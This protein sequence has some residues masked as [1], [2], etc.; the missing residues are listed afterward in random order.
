MKKVLFA[1][2]LVAAFGL[3]SCSSDSDSTS[4]DN[5]VVAAQNAIKSKLAGIML[6]DETP[7]ADKV[8]TPVDFHWEAPFNVVEKLPE[9]KTPSAVY[10]NYYYYATGDPFT[11][12]MLYSNGLY[13]HICGIY[14]YDNAGNYYEEDMWD[15]RTLSTKD[16]YN[17]N[18][19]SNTEKK[20]SRLTDK[21]GAYEI[22]L[23][24]NTK[25]GFYQKSYYPSNNKYANIVY[26]TTETSCTRCGGDGKYGVIKCTTCNGTGKIST[27][28]KD[29]EFKFFSELSLNWNGKCQTV[30][31]NIDESDWT[32]VGLEDISRAGTNT[33]GFTSDEDFNDCVFAVNP[34]LHIVPLPVDSDTIVPPPTP[35]DP[36][37]IPTPDPIVYPNQGSV[38]TNLSVTEKDGQGLVRLSL[39]V[40]DT[41]DVEIILPFT[42]QALA[43]DFAIVAKHDIEASYSEPIEINGHIV[44]LKYSLTAEGYL[45]ITTKGINA[46]VLEYCRNT[47]ADGLTFECNLL[48]PAGAKISGT[49]TITFTKEPYVYITSCVNNSAEANDMEV[50]WVNGGA[51]VYENGNFGDPEGLTYDHKFYSKHT[52]QEIKE[53]GWFEI[54]EIEE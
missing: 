26:G 36:D 40:R 50:V 46:E 21:A 7:I 14:W 35:I 42:D 53:L 1:L 3:T 11:V 37:T 43:D 20:I 45:K 2:A 12:V 16:W 41:T 27:T 48:L 52:L 9:G 30:T 8:V 33:S 15:E 29:K 13:R 28:D 54:N 49:P 38:E 24:K 44:E 18:G 10:S 47:Y 6:L 25:F 17:P 4:P 5:E 32:V 22:N 23:P 19:G 31:F 34:K 39:H 51:L